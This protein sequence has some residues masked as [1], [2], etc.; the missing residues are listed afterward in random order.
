MEPASLCD[1]LMWYLVFLLVLGGLAVLPTWLF[2]RS[3]RIATGLGA[4]ACVVIGVLAP[5]VWLL[6][7]MS[8]QPATS[9][10][11]RVGCTSATT[12]S[13]P[14]TWSIWWSSRARLG[15]TGCG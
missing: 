3:G 9:W 4:G 2:W 8:E 7:G 13:R 6:G 12:P 1:L 10:G 11:T 14:C 15:P 5:I